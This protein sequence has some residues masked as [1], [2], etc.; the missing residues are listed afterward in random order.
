MWL[1]SREFHEAERSFHLFDVIFLWKFERYF[2]TE[3][4]V[5]GFDFLDFLVHMT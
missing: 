1:W 5:K 3:G 4:L 2:Y